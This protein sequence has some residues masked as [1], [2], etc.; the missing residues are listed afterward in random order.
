MQR[1]I[2]TREGEGALAGVGRKEAEVPSE[3]SQDHVRLWQSARFQ[4]EL[5]CW[6]EETLATTDSRVVGPLK[7]HRIRF[8]AA[9]FTLET[10]NGV[11][12]V[13]T[14]NPGQRFEVG[15]TAALAKIVPDCVQT[16]WAVEDDRGW[17]LMPDGGMTL[18]QRGSVSQVD[19]EALLVQ[20][21][22]LQQR[23]AEHGAVLAS[24]GLPAL[25]S[26]QA[27]GYAVDLIGE[28]AARPASDPQHLSG[29][30]ERDLHRAVD[31]VARDFDMLTHSGVPN[32]LQPN[33]VSAANVFVTEVPDRFTMFDLGDA[34]WS[35]PYAVL[36]ASLRMVGGSWPH[37]PNLGDPLIQEL[38]KS[39]FLAWGDQ[40]SAERRRALVKAA[41]RLGS[42]HR[43]QSWRRL[44]AYTDVQA[45][46][47]GPPPLLREW[48]SQALL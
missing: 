33:D 12:W 43:C 27:V 41:D 19:W 30:Q 44:L 32:S 2:M 9:L 45:L 15:L 3:P 8:W 25:T 7:V 6:A 17:L 5:R 31:R 48:L 11:V 38:T 34:F 18:A 14:T 40:S 28:L 16:P 29:R 35:H 1:G 37:P 23:L 42:L 21:A 26:E 46:V 24:E 39:Y 10:T 22:E 36:H 20:T 47:P 4:E 13:K